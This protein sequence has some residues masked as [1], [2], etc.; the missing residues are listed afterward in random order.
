MT[1]YEDTAARW[2]ELARRILKANDD[3]EE[4]A[5]LH[6]DLTDLEKEVAFCHQCRGRCN[7]CIRTVEGYKPAIRGSAS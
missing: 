4:A 7:S 5:K 3:P 2:Q 1:D 6:A